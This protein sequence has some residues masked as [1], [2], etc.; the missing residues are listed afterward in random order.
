MGKNG[1][2]SEESEG[3]I[4]KKILDRLNDLNRIKWDDVEIDIVQEVFSNYQYYQ[5]GSGIMYIDFLTLPGIAREG[6]THI[7][8]FRVHLTIK[9]AKNLIENIHEFIEKAGQE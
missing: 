5:L 9:N 6:K 8:G 3:D 2:K 7:N 4:G 1:E